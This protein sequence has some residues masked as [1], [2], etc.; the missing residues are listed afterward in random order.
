VW[1]RNAVQACAASR[2]AVG[3]LPPASSNSIETWP[4]S[5]SRKRSS[6]RLKHLAM[7]C[8]LVHT[9]T[10]PHR[11]TLRAARPLQRVLVA[12]GISLQ[13]PA[14]CPRLQT[15][16]YPVESMSARN[17]SYYTSGQTKTGASA[18]TVQLRN[19]NQSYRLRQS[20]EESGSAVALIRDRSVRASRR[21][22]CHRASRTQHS[23]SDR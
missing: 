11:E 23:D 10:R 18:C 20:R 19:A 6:P 22:H 15:L 8:K 16:G 2:H 3:M 13:A 7:H 4:A 17:P 5:K 9:C 1:Q 21:T 14:A 12:E